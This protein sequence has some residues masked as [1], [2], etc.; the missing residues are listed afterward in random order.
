[1]NIGTN[2][3]PMSSHACQKSNVPAG[4][5]NSHP[6]EYSGP[7][8]NWFHW[9]T[10]DFGQYGQFNPDY[11]W[12]TQG[13]EVFWDKRCWA[14]NEL[15]SVENMEEMVKDNQLDEWEVDDNKGGTYI[16]Q[17]SESNCLYSRDW[18]HKKKEVREMRGALLF[19]F[20]CIV[21]RGS[22]WMVIIVADPKRS[23]SFC[24][25]QTLC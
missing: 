21:F 25:S 22:R 24:S 16:W 12:I 14:G 19:Y 9:G 3:T 20:G 8:S 5:N 23:R 17:P 4:R 13:D 2:N 15:C 11:T 18:A 10:F 6:D 1:M 7:N